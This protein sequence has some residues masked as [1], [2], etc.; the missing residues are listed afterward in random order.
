MAPAAGA[1]G[2]GPAGKGGAG[3]GGRP[4]PRGLPGLRRPAVGVG[5]A[6]GAGLP[7]ALSRLRRGACS[8]R[9]GCLLV[10]L[11]E[12]NGGEGGHESSAGAFSFSG[13]PMSLPRPF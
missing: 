7:P 13:T 12:W 3:R 9:R 5:A 1:A 11:F 10:A 6:P 4:A 2:L 8:G